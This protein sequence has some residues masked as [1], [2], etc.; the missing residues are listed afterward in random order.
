MRFLD[1][2]RAPNVEVIP[3]DAQMQLDAATYFHF[4]VRVESVPLFVKVFLDEEGRDPDVRVIS[5]KRDDR[6]WSES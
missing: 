5:V 6:A 4:R 1:E 3:G 2:G